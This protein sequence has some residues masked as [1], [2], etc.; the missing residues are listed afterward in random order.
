M[1]ASMN[2]GTSSSTTKFLA[3]GA[4]VLLWP[5]I[6][7]ACSVR[8]TGDPIGANE[9][10]ATILFLACLMLLPVSLI[11]WRKS[12]R[13]RGWAVAHVLLIVMNPIWWVSAVSGDCGYSLATLA[14]VFVVVAALGTARVTWLFLRKA[15]PVS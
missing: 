11:V 9:R 10:L 7:L 15:A 13:Y 12:Q 5:S 3:A 6:A 1:N 8:G 4:G 14:T 2:S